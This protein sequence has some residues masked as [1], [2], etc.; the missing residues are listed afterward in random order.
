MYSDRRQPLN[1]NKKWL[2]WQMLYF[3]KLWYWL[4]YKEGHC[5][6][7]D[8]IWFY[9][10]YYEQSLVTL[11]TLTRLELTDYED[12]NLITP[13]VKEA[14][15][16]NFHRS[17]LSYFFENKFGHLYQEKHTSST[18]NISLSYTWKVIPLIHSR[19]PTLIKMIFLFFK[20]KNVIFFEQ[21]EN[22]CY[23]RCL[24]RY[25]S[26]NCLQKISLTE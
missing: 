22:A 7:S 3:A 25:F 12:I 13:S 15:S 5:Q 10:F 4:F 17:F 16:K 1:I 24:S 26:I 21:F 19:L 23:L 20:P 14:F 18:Y 8:A 2:C 11:E 6:L 9:I